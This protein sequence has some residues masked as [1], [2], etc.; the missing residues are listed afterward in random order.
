M[1]FDQRLEAAEEI[2]RGCPTAVALV[3]KRTCPEPNYSRRER[4]QHMCATEFARRMLGKNL[5]HG[6]AYLRRDCGGPRIPRCQ[7]NRA[8]PTVDAADSFEKQW[9]IATSQP[10]PYI[11][12]PRSLDRPQSRGIKKSCRGEPAF[13]NQLLDSASAFEPT[14]RVAG[15]R[16]SF[17]ARLTYIDAL[18]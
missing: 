7:K 11:L 8:D 17:H 5:L 12:Y 3:G 1:C 14:R 6:G 15:G 18:T 9:L 13:S 2:G 16:A 4:P 10:P